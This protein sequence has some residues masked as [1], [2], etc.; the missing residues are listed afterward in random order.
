LQ[1]YVLGLLLKNNEGNLWNDAMYQVMLEK[2]VKG[3]FMKI[4]EQKT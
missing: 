2:Y 4:K 1:R 3:I